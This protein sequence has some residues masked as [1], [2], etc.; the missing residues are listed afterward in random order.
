L[1]PWHGACFVSERAAHVRTC[2]GV[3]Q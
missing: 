1:V 2:N 3:S